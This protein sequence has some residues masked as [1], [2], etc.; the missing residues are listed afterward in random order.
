MVDITVYDGEEKV[1][2]RTGVSEDEFLKSLRTDDCLLFSKKQFGKTTTIRIP[3]GTWDIMDALVPKILKYCP[4]DIVEV[5]MGESTT[6]FADHAYEKG[7]ELYSCDIQMG[8]MFK[9]FDKPIFEGHHCFIGRSESFMKEYEGTPSIVFLD[10]E[11]LYETVK[12]E[13]EFFLPKIVPGGVMFMHDTFP[14][15]ERMTKTD[16]DG[17]SPGNIYKARQALECRTDVDVFTW[18]YSA[19]NMGLTMVM[20]H[21]KNRP[22]WRENGAKIL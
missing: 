8:G 3:M 4:G 17:Y 16:P 1:N 15:H 13:V 5:G 19:L 2:Y 11:H 20:K 14:E 7:V 6:I 9:V 22:Y 18:P 21:E 10:G 12:K